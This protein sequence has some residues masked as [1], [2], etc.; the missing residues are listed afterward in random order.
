[1]I[2]EGDRASKLD[3]V[4]RAAMTQKVAASESA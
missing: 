4:L 3:V 1:M 2:W